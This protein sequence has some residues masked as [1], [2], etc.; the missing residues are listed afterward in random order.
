[1]SKNPAAIAQ[2]VAKG[3]VLLIIRMNDVNYR[4]VDMRIDS[5]SVL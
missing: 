3:H 4:I 2:G 1:M 5:V